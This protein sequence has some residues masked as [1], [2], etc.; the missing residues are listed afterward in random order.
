MQE[1]TDDWV[2][3][4]DDEIAALQSELDRSEKMLAYLRIAFCLFAG[5]WLVTVWLL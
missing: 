3:S 1:L 2:T 5:A 4:A